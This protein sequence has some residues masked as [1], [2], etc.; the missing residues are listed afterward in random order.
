MF[1]HSGWCT[2]VRPGE[3]DSRAAHLSN[4]RGKERIC[5]VGTADVSGGG[6]GG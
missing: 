6:E 4:L 5:Q 3:E 2:Q 1:K